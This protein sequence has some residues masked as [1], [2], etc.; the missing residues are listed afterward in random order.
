ML[1]S[2][3]APREL[4]LKVEHLVLVHPG[5][6]L[7]CKAGARFVVAAY[8]GQALLVSARVAE[9]AGDEQVDTVIFGVLGCLLQAVVDAA[10]QRFI[11]H[12]EAVAV[13]VPDAGQIFAVLNDLQVLLP[14]L[15]GN[16]QD[17]S[18]T[19]ED[20]LGST[21]CRRKELL[22][23]RHLGVDVAVDVL[24]TELVPNFDL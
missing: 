6:F 21:S 9:R 10:H 18:C 4:C 8:T 7:E 16:F 17:L 2:D 19:A 22:D 1:L 11:G 5:N 15:F 3:L 14:R 23:A 24:V 13:H 12:D 20:E